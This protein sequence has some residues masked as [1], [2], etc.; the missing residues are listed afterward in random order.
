MENYFKR[1]GEKNY[2]IFEEEVWQENFKYKMMEYNQI[3]A[4]LKY[5]IYHVDNKTR[6]QY[7]ISS[8]QSL[9][10]ICEKKQLKKQNFRKLLLG[11][12][13]AMQEISKYF[14]RIDE[15]FLDPEY[16]YADMESFEIYFCYHP[17]RKDSFACEE[18]HKLTE[19]IINHLDY[20][21]KELIEQGYAL[22]RYTLQEN[23]DIRK[24][25]E[26]IVKHKK[27]HMSKEMEE[28]MEEEKQEQVYSEEKNY[29]KVAESGFFTNFFQR[30]KGDNFSET[31]K[32]SEEILANSVTE[33][34]E[35]EEIYGHT[36]LLKEVSDKPGHYLVALS[37]GGYQDFSILKFPFVIGKGKEWADG[38]IPN[39][40]ISRIH[41]QLEEED[42]E[43]YITDLNSTNGTWAID[44]QLQATETVQLK[45]GDIINFSEIY[46]RFV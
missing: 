13:E 41:A 43:I 22:Y 11:I 27:G 23:Y 26:E 19:Y 7:D 45:S 35:E 21:D 14:L 38:V 42:G 25:I 16:I 36:M 9:Q 28:T 31:E 33:V 5:K 4:L 40:L 1:E 34:E 12:L 29:S 18:F 20:E 3:K 39:T 44:V 10:R 32:Q 37:E 17:N 46:Y 24:S 15:L 2:L 30:F 8:K 6:I